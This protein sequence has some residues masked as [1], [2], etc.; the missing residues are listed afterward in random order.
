MEN[1]LLTF[2]FHEFPV[3]IATHQNGEVFFCLKDVCDCL[4]ITNPQNVL[5]R[6]DKKGVYQIH[7]LTSGGIQTLNFI[8]EPLPR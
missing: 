4:D 1:P 8:N 6:L 3:H 2:T 7:A 5:N